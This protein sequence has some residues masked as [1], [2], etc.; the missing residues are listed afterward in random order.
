MTIITVVG[1]DK[2]EIEKELQ[3]VLIAETFDGNKNKSDEAVKLF[4]ETFAEDE[5]QTVRG[6]AVQSKNWRT[7]GAPK[8][9]EMPMEI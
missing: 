5:K 4:D 7:K 6:I 9:V 3:Y 8:Y 2:S 1:L